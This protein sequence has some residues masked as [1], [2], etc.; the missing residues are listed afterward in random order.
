MINELGILNTHIPEHHEWYGVPYPGFFMVDRDGVVFEK[1]FINEHWVR[2]SVGNVLRGSFGVDGPQVGESQR[3]TTPYLAARA[4]FTSETIRI[5]QLTTLIV[6]V[7]LSD[8]VHVLGTSLPEGFIPLELNLDADSDIRIEKI[9][10][11]GP[12]EMEL[13]V[14]GEKL[15]V[16]FGRFRV[17]AKCLCVKGGIG[18]ALRG[19]NEEQLNI[20]ATL[21]F[22]ACDETQCYL[23][24]TLRFTLPLQLLPHDWQEIPE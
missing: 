2:E 16:Y 10:Y 11:P 9:D 15:P 6:E 17:K 3:V 7:S 5:G 19:S 4:F 23:P 13:E 22:Q 24:E 21:R 12:V 1:S 18:E 8:D 20:N 14:I